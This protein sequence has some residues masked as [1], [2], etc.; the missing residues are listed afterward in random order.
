MTVHSIPAVTMTGMKELSG[1]IIWYDSSFEKTSFG[2][3]IM[4][5]I[6]DHLEEILS[7]KRLFLKLNKIFILRA[8]SSEDR[9]YHGYGEAHDFYITH[10]EI[11][12]R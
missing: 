9:Y 8:Q 4:E 1:A 3:I 12:G 11:T 2:V 5:T 7:G 10:I 6:K